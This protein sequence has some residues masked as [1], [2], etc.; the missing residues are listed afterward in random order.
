MNTI[1][2]FMSLSDCMSIIYPYY[3]ISTIIL[4]RV[5]LSRVVSPLTFRSVQ[6]VSCAFTPAYRVDISGVGIHPEVVAVR[7]AV[8][9]EPKPVTT[10]LGD[11]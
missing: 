1:S 4:F 3:P 10:D 6:F 9:M 7:V 5:Y 2:S 11:T 8:K